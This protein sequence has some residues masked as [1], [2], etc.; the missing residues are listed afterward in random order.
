MAIKD[1]AL[2]GCIPSAIKSTKLYAINPV[3]GKGDLDYTGGVS[4]YKYDAIGSLKKVPSNLPALN[5]YVTNGEVNGFPEM[6]MPK[7][8]TNFLKGSVNL[9]SSYSWQFINSSNTENVTD[10]INVTGVFGVNKVFENTSNAQHYAAQTITTNTLSNGRT[11]AFSMYI[12]PVGREI[13]RVQLDNT[14]DDTCTFFFGSPE[15]PKAD[16]ENNGNQGK[17]KVLPNGWYRISCNFTM[18]SSSATTIRLLT[19]KLV[20][21]SVAST[22]TG[23]SQKGWLMWGIQLESNTNGSATEPSPLIETTTISV[24]RSAPTLKTNIQFVK[25]PTDYP[26]SI[27]WEGRIDRY[28]AQ[29]Q[30]WSLY[31]SSGGNFVLSLTFNSD[32]IMRVDRANGSTPISHNIS[33]RTM[34]DDYLKI[35][36]VFF[37]EY[38]FAIYIN[39]F[40]VASFT[41]AYAGF[42]TTN[43]LRIGCGNADDDDAGQRQSFKQLFLWNIALTDTQAI[44]ETSYISFENMA[45]SGNFKLA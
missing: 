37:D 38:T 12:K 27:Y 40:F 39:G 44:T 21:G 28:A 10:S 13:L 4:A 42:W 1:T 9:S 35:I 25:F 23:E 31:N 34:K 8:R 16:A 29:Q 22:F 5:Y 7:A 33:Y 11:Y 43:L 41:H 2:F 18:T 32:T 36:V 26:V 20:N 15:V 3:D 30:A 45:K 6:Q 17:I 14:T 19:Q 24:T